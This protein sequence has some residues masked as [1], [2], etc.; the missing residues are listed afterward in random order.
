MILYYCSFAAVD[1]VLTEKKALLKIEVPTE[2][3]E[4]YFPKRLWQAL[5]ENEYNGL[6]G[7]ADQLTFK[8]KTTNPRTKGYSISFQASYAA[9]A[10]LYT[11]RKGKLYGG[12]T[13]YTVCSGDT[14]K[15]MA[16]FPKDV[17]FKARM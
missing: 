2:V 5:M 1:I 15:P 8:G 10:F 14:G 12:M 4:T 16:A 6:T 11:H 3:A 7:W 9:C 17:I 13:S